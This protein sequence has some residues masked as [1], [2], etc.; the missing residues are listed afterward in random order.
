M[1]YDVAEVACPAGQ[2]DPRS[3]RPGLWQRGRA[4]LV[5]YLQPRC[6][7]SLPLLWWGPLL[8]ALFQVPPPSSDRGRCCTCDGF[9]AGW[10]IAYLMLSWNSFG[11]N[12]FC[13]L[14]FS[15]REGHDEFD[16]KEHQVA[17]YQVPQ[18]LRRRTWERAGVRPTPSTML[19]REQ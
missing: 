16:R 10:L 3:P 13:K 8:P 4:A 11:F 14:Y 6:Y 9:V 7:C 12:Y 1:T 18:K 15:P 17:S 5:L 19:M 2:Q